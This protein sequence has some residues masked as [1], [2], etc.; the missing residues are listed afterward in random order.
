MIGLHDGLG[1]GMLSAP[2]CGAPIMTTMV[3]IFTAMSYTRGLEGQPPVHYR[4]EVVPG[5]GDVD[6]LQQATR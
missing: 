6:T 3:L 5:N 1:P 4:H 2:A